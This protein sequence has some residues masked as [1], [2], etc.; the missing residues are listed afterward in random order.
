MAFKDDHFSNWSCKNRFGYASLSWNERISTFYIIEK[1]VNCLYKT[2]ICY[3]IR[4]NANLLKVDFREGIE[5]ILGEKHNKIEVLFRYRQI[6]NPNILIILWIL[7]RDKLHKIWGNTYTSRTRLL[8]KYPQISHSKI[9]E[10]I[11]LHKIFKHYGVTKFFTSV[12]FANPFS[13]LLISVI[14]TLLWN[15]Q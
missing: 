2:I 15:S 12:D 13:T 3:Q 6:C 1:W 4:T 7:Q 11:L 9:F 10:T 14:F 8:A 5:L